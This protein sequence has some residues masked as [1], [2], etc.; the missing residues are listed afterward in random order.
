MHRRLSS[1]FLASRYLLLTYVSIL[2]CFPYLSIAPIILVAADHS[3]C[4][5]TWVSKTSGKCVLDG[6]TLRL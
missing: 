6:A 2:S 5:K 1:A 4:E 3:F